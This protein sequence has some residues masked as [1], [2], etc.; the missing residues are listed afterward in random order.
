[1]GG[2]AHRIVVQQLAQEAEAL[3]FWTD[4]E[5][6]LPGRE[7]V[8]LAVG[9]GIRRIA[10]EVA[11]TTNTGHEIENLTKCLAG[12]F[13]PVVSVSPHAHIVGSIEAAARRL[14]ADGGF[15]DEQ[16]ARLRFLSPAQFVEFLK[17]VAEDEA[18]PPEKEK[19]PDFKVIGGRRVA[20]RRAE[21][22]PEQRKI[23]DEGFR[24]VAEIISRSRSGPPAP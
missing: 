16:F 15:T 19:A 13:D 3:R 24:A 9:N 20:I 10:V 23:E 11:M 18:Q 12:D 4:R 1:V 17:S 2:P 7:R 5:F 6:T 22:T 21:R 8:D 14:L